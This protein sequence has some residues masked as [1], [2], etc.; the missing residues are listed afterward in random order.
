VLWERLAR[1]IDS[2][3]DRA[4]V[5]F[6]GPD[7]AGKTFV[8][9]AVAA[10]VRRPTVRASIDGFHK[11][12]EV[13]LRH[14]VSAPDSYYNDG[15]DYRALQARLLLPFRSGADSVDVAIYDYRRDVA[16]I[17]VRRGLP[18]GAV[19][20][21]DGVFLLRHELRDQWTLRV[22]LD[23]TP[24][25]TLRRVVLRDAGLFGSAVAVVDRY[26]VRYLPAQDLYAA[27]ANPRANAHIVIDNNDFENPRA[28]S[29]EPPS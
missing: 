29:W 4:T 24:E 22:Y 23:V 8:A 21:C 2:L 7:A 28:I 9:D 19:L 12:R 16:D 26:K 27:D 11:P 5:A 13:R 3:D 6:D 25:T 20:L 14:G 18:A 1:L 17:A 10:R 15:F